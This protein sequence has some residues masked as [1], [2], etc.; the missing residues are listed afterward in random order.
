MSTSI[1][2]ERTVGEEGVQ[3]QTIDRSTR[4]LPNIASSGFHMPPEILGVPTNTN[5]QQN[6]VPETPSRKSYL[7]DVNARSRK[8]SGSAVKAT[9]SKAAIEAA[10]RAVKEA[11]KRTK[12]ALDSS[13]LTLL[14][15]QGTEIVFA[16]TDGKTVVGVC[17]RTHFLFQTLTLASKAPIISITS[18][19][20]SGMLIVAHED[21][22][23]RT[24][25]PVP[26]QPCEFGESTR[27]QIPR[28]AFG[29]FRW[30][31]SF[32]IDA[33]NIFYQEQENPK[34]LD[35]R[36]AKPGQLLDISSSTDCR[37]LIAHRKQIAVLEASYVEGENHGD[38]AL[39]WTTILPSN[40]VTAKISGDGQAVVV[41][42][43]VQNETGVYGAM[44]FAHDMEDGSESIQRP[45]L[46]RKS[47]A[48]IVYKPGPF[49][50]HSTPVTRIS[51]RGLG[52]ET[53]KVTDDTGQGNDLL[54]TYCENDSSNRIFN[55]NSWQQ[56]MFWSAPPDSRA[57][58]IR[59]TSAFSLGDLESQQKMKN[60]PKH[61]RR[62]SDTSIAESSVGGVNMASRNIRS[63]GLGAPTTSAGAWIGEITFRGAFPALR[64]SRL[65]YMKRG[66][67][68]SQPAHFESVAAVLPAGSIVADSI[69]EADDMGLTIQGVWPAWNPWL[70]ES[71]DSGSNDLLSGSAMQFLGLSPV[72]P[73]ASAFDDSY[74]GGSLSPPTEL[75]IAASHPRKGNLVLM[76]FPLWGDE[77][78][79][80]MELG[81]PIRSVLSLSDAQLSNR[82]SDE[83]A[84]VHPYAS[85][86]Y[87]TSRLCASVDPI[88]NSIS[89]LLRRPGSMSLYSPD[90]RGDEE[91]TNITETGD[92]PSTRLFHD[93]STIPGPL[94]LPPLYLP[95]RI[96]KENGNRIVALKWWPDASFA[97]PPLLL[98]ITKSATCIVFEVAPPWSVIEPTMPNHDP[99]NAP[100][101]GSDSMSPNGKNNA[102]RSN[103]TTD[104]EEELAHRRKEYV[105]RVTPHPDFGLG[106]RLE[107]PMDGTPAV[108]GSF[109]KH[110]LN[111]GMLP[112]EKTG[113]II[114]GDE[115][116][117][118]N[119]VSLENM[120]FDDIIATVR[121]VGAKSGP[122]EALALRFRPAP[123]GRSKGNSVAIHESLNAR[124]L[125]ST[126]GND[127]DPTPERMLPQLEETEDDDGS[128]GRTLLEM[129]GD[130]Q[131][132]FGRLIGVVRECFP[133][134]ELQD[135]SE[136]LFV[137][138]WRNVQTS[139]LSSKIR[140]AALMIVA[141]GGRLLARRLELVLDAAPGEARV[142]ELGEY[143]FSKG[144]EES[145]SVQIR[146]VKYIESARTSLAFAVSDNLGTVE[147]VVLKFQGND[148]EASFCHYSA[149]SL[150][151][152]SADYKVCPSSMNL[153]ATV[154]T[155]TSKPSQTITMWSARPDPSC[156]RFISDTALKDEHCDQDYI[157]LQIEVDSADWDAS[158][159]DFRFLPTGYLDHFP[160]LVVF[161]KSE[162]IVYQFRGESLKWHPIVRLT[163][164][165]IPDS[166]SQSS[167][168]AN[169]EI[170]ESIAA[171]ETFPH[172]LPSLRATLSSNDEF[173]TC[174]SDWHP[175][176]LLTY[177]FT[178][179]RGASAA[180]KL[181]VRGI[182]IWLSEWIERS[183]DERFPPASSPLFVPPFDAVGGGGLFANEVDP[184]DGSETTENAAML[185]AS[186]L[187]KKA[188]NAEDPQRAKLKALLDKLEMQVPASN[189]TQTSGRSKEF[190]Q[191]MLEGNSHGKGDV[192]A[193][194]SCVLRT[195]GINE[196]RALWAIVE[197]AMNPPNSRK[198]DC[199]AQMALMTF[200]LH[201]AV[202][203]SPIEDV[204]DRFTKSS[205]SGRRRAPSYY[206]K[207]QSSAFSEEKTSLPPQN[208]SAGCAAA[209][210]SDY[211]GQ[212][213]ESLRQVGT[214]LD[215]T[216]AREVR[217]PFWLRS[218]DLLRSI[219]EEIGQSLYRQSKDILKSSLFF[220]LA[221]KKK[222]LKNL[223]AADSTLSGRKFYKFLSDFDFGSSRGRSAAEKNAFS[224]LRKN[225]YDC[226]A[227]FFLLAEPPILKSAVETIASKMGDV[228]LAFMVARLLGNEKA[229]ALPNAGIG[230]SGGMMGYGTNIV[231][232]G[233]GYAGVG[234]GDPS[235]CAKDA[236][237][238]SEW[239][240]SLCTIASDLLTD[241]VLPESYS[242]A[243]FS[244]VQLLWLDRRDEA[245]HWLSGFVGSQDGLFPEFSTDVCL[246]RLCQI[247]RRKSRS[248]TI[249]ALNAFINFVAG[250]LL[251]KMMEASNRTRIASA[252][253][254]SNS[255]ARLGFE[256]PCLRLISQNVDQ[257]AVK[258]SSSN[259]C[260]TLGSM[261]SGKKRSPVGTQS[262]GN[263]QAPGMAASSIFD[264]FDAA[265]RAKPTATRSSSNDVVQS[266][267]FDG[268]DAA[269]Q[270]T[271]A[272]PAKGR[273]QSNI[274]SKFD[275]APPEESPVSTASAQG[276]VK[277]SIFD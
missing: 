4:G 214:K 28:S 133:P 253:L 176:S 229:S 257:I 107:S 233:G 238:F 206:V 2:N 65:S 147:I 179:E 98:A 232:G 191:A 105:A 244:A 6:S 9:K 58:W 143:D 213:V 48:G 273:G 75:R 150:D 183:L 231:G 27:D 217:L 111:G 22:I 55:Q 125:D 274:F 219:S 54:L 73:P 79:G 32:T 43:D 129:S 138:P 41:V 170:V 53:S 112:A 197:V 175:E 39:L 261:S 221:G 69:L 122:G 180:L 42:L 270:V 96:A 116:L 243:A 272:S 84:E 74:L 132:E 235:E 11:G 146:K 208:S 171:C 174:V 44:T 198:L 153:I 172:L 24:Y 182:L 218:D 127:S 255:L 268:F 115:L 158:I 148:N 166:T 131:Q 190:K 136:L 123:L 29:R 124:A 203:K 59:G 275:V 68:D 45:N 224:L 195:L 72:P 207:K 223:A 34:F 216:I 70:S 5:Q 56:L 259:G 157:P 181:H 60:T 240:P 40:I 110:P 92:L 260:P 108:A 226:A 17:S 215:W 267:I 12:V 66:N 103:S 38:A 151:S 149:F 266:S 177:I 250:P 88:S 211:Q 249:N 77:E 35:R 178:D 186:F 199:Q 168:T 71:I 95:L 33:S 161:M 236:K 251:L 119:G 1:P 7:A 144:K 19:S 14:T 222:M 80:A 137:L 159:Q 258:E 16:N 169:R 155:G 114:L 245:S 204:S 135:I 61:S 242:D 134:I 25:R 265:P 81:S 118:V 254:V 85:M 200:A 31:N 101:Y 87:E 167:R 8:R 52:R 113:M 99:F 120:T 23:I 225:R 152:D 117:S 141:V 46:R 130:I 128:L 3:S 228:D 248:Q 51:F 239:K 162:S 237:T 241:R 47:S 220:I 21:G 194:V 189:V 264:S 227:A 63:V 234:M 202:K 86:E 82:R 57:D 102:G 262:V 210:F 247:Q 212:L 142:V 263:K 18:N 97:G 271:P 164:P 30:V 106:L 20:Q 145:K 139:P 15:Y 277:S 83:Q 49:L 78:F 193:N 91:I 205:A 209:L 126:M 173:K 276:Q 37:V 156:R 187:S 184:M 188:K 13:M 252:L 160:A 10:T 67:D 89:L 26:T 64:L 256:L 185:M 163:Y 100:L 62:P 154:P 50:E 104:E 93:M 76:E 201:S 94:A 246:P 165:S 109:K 230:F 121:H 90:W 269:P 140:E 192:A 36:S 196:M